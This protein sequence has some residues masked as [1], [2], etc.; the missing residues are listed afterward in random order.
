MQAPKTP[1]MNLDSVLSRLAAAVMAL[2][3]L[4]LVGL[5]GYGLVV[6]LLRW[7]PGMFGELAV[8]G[9]LGAVG[10]FCS[11][12]AYRLFIR[13]PMLNVPGW[14]TLAAVFA[15]IGVLPILVGT[16]IDVGGMVSSFTFAALCGFGA[17]TR[18]RSNHNNSSGT[19][20]GYPT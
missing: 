15:G 17:F 2:I 4:G 12:I 9:G 5:G 8:F 7:G 18:T 14:I 6:S 11:L 13:V 3:G 16:P 1:E 10:G 20:A 19:R